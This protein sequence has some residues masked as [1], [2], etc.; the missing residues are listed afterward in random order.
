MGYMPRT[1]HTYIQPF[2]PMRKAQTE[3]AHGFY[4][5]TTLQGHLFF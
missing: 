1:L 3:A 5:T 4:V 2:A